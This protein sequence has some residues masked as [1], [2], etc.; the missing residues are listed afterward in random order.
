[1]IINKNFWLADIYATYDT[2]KKKLTEWNLYE[3]DTAKF[4]KRMCVEGDMRACK[5]EGQSRNGQVWQ[6]NPMEEQAK[7]QGK[8]LKLFVS[9]ECKIPRDI[10]RKT[11][12]ITYSIDNAD[13]VAAHID[14]NKIQ[15]YD[16]EYIKAIT[17]EDGK[18]LVRYFSLSLQ[19]V[20][21]GY[22]YRY[23]DGDELEYR[24]A[25]Q[26]LVEQRIQNMYECKSFCNTQ[27][28][29]LTTMP[30]DEAME[31]LINN[32]CRSGGKAIIA[33]IHLKLEYPVEMTVDTLFALLSCRD[34]TIANKTL[35]AMDCERYPFT[36]NFVSKKVTSQVA[37][38]R[39]TSDMMMLTEILLR[40]G[41]AITP[42]DFNL[43]QELQFKLLGV[44]EQGLMYV[45]HFN[46]CCIDDTYIAK[47][48][49][50]KKVKIDK[51]M[52]VDELR[53]LFEHNE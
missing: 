2:E 8:K 32:N 23:K 19:L 40:N 21:N 43:Y 16:E 27:H 25:A 30:S 39:R 12:D 28:I 11:Y 33:D 48:I 3:K 15:T 1:M 37:K 14:E 50:V 52:T 44:N 26:R 22:S 49:A 9:P 18:D 47:K 7:T 20:R 5:L 51:P 34:Y 35:G 36:Y 13:A 17:E 41:R 46:K 45:D 31:L 38:T 53:K 6:L 42:E 10:I 24:S 29:T 4:R